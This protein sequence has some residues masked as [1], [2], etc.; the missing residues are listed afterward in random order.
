MAPAFAEALNEAAD[1]YDFVI[2][3][4]PPSG[5]ILQDAALAA[6]RYVL[7]PI[8]TDALSWRALE[9]LGPLV[10]KARAGNPELVYL[11]ALIF[12]SHTT[13]TRLRGVT[14]TK[15]GAFGETVPLFTTFIR[16]SETYGSDASIKGLL[17]HEVARASDTVEAERLR[18]LRQRSDGVDG[19]AA[20]VTA[21]SRTARG[22]AEDYGELLREVIARISAHED[23]PTAA[24]S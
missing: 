15:L 1:G 2:V 8:T 20:P 18:A 4:C 21:L 7:V 24:R 17:A 11:G 22:V 5:N 10:K 23:A 6:A 19:T 16:D 3:D 9:E 13:T 12:R 14:R